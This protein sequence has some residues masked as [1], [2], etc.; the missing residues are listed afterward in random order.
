MRNPRK[1]KKPSVR[2]CSHFERYGRRPGR[3]GIFCPDCAY[4]IPS[5]EP[6]GDIDLALLIAATINQFVESNIIDGSITCAG[7]VRDVIDIRLVPAP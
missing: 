2:I 5:T 1:A 6:V 7:C 4:Q 3:M